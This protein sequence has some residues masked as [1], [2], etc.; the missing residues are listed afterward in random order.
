MSDEKEQNGAQRVVYPPASSSPGA[1]NHIVSVVLQAGERV[2][3]EWT[4][5]PGGERFV[6]GYRI[7][8]AWRRPRRRPGTT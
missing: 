5:L 7:L 8:P 2:L 1:P 4:I 3:W 6:S